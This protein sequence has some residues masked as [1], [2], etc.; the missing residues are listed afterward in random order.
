MR[1]KLLSSLLAVTMVTG[2]LAGCGGSGS[3]DSG[4][5]TTAPATTEAATQGGGDETPT[6]ESAGE[7]VTLKWAIWDK[8]ATPYWIALQE[9]Y[10]ESHPNVKIEMVDLGS[11]LRGQRGERRERINQ[12]QSPEFQGHGNSPFLH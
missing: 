6:T 10:E 11:D 12:H 1:K 3:G 8:D 7:D 2:L 5:D 4:K 9:A